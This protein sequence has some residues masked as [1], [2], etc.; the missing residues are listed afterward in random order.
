MLAPLSKL[1]SKFS[2]LRP[3]FL[4]GLVLLLGFLQLS[5]AQNP[6]F[7]IFKNFFVTGDY[8]VSGWV[9][10]APDGS[11]Y[12]PGIISIP[13]TKQPVATSV[14]KGADIVAA[15]L[16]WATVEGNQSA[17]V[18][19]QAFFNGYSLTGTVLGSPN[20]PVSWSSG[21]CSGSAQGSKTMRYY[22]ADV[23]PYLPL[24]T[25]NASPTFG[26][27]VA[28]GN[29]PVRL[30]DSGGNGNSAPFALGASLVVVYRVL[31]P[32]TPLNGIVLYDGIVAPSNTSQPV[33]Q[34]ITGFYGPTTQQQKLTQIV[35]NGQMNKSEFVYLNGQPLPSIYGSAPP[36]P[37]I[38][39][40]WDNPT[41][42]VNGD[43]TTDP[44]TI[45]V[46][47]S[48]SNSGCVSWGAM[49]LST[50]VQ[51]TDHDGLL[52]VWESNQGYTDAVSG[53]FVALPGANP[54]VPDIFVELDYLSN[55]DGQ[56]GSYLHSHLPKQQALDNVGSIYANHGI[57]VHYD[58]GPTV[59]QGD[60]YVIVGGNG[61]N[62]VSEGLVLCT[63]GASLCQFPGQPAIG[64][65]GGFEFF[66]NDATLGNFQSARSQTYHYM[67]FGHSLGGPRSFWSTLGSGVADPTI[68]TVVS[69]VN[70]GPTAT[71]TIRSP[72]GIVKPGD[73]PSPL[74]ACGDANTNRVTISGA[75]AQTALNG[76]FVFKNAVSSAP[77]VNGL[78]T[79]TFKITTANVPN[80]TYSYKSSCA[81]CF[82]EPQLGISYLGPTS[83][84]GHSDFGGGGDSMVTL[85][86]WA[87]DDV[88]GCQADPSQ[89]S[90]VYCNNQVGTTSVQTGT[91]AHELGHDLTWTHGGTYYNDPISNPSLPTYDVNC[92]PNFLSVMNYL[93]QVRGFVDGGFDYS[94]QTL[95]PLSE[96]SNS[97]SEALGIGQ[98]FST[99]PAA[100]LTRWY[101][102]PNALDNQLQNSSGGRFATAHCDGSP[103]TPGEAPAV[104]VDATVA[105]GG[106]F[107]APLD[108]NNDLI[109]P[110]TI[111][112]PGVDLDHNGAIG[113]APF[114]RFN[115]WNVIN[116]QQIGARSSAFGFSQA[117]GL[118]NGGGGLK[119][120]GGGTDNDGG[121]LKNGG[122][123]LKNGGGG[124][125]NGGGGTEQ[126]ET[127]ATST[128]DAPTALRCSVAI[129]SVPACVPSAS[130]FQENGKNVP[131]TWDAPGFGQIRK[132]TIYRAV[133]S[134]TGQ[135]VVLNASKFSPIK[136]LTGAPPS[137]SYVDSSVKNGTT[138]TYLV[139]AANKQGAESGSS[140][141]LV[142]TVK[143]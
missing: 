82:N 96:A 113:G 11:G 95:P 139:T 3:F 127:T 69:V 20:A 79:T 16:Y 7:H 61:G 6:D 15:Y 51:D 91:L 84:S 114:L 107:S 104:R 73:C 125:K 43:V 133:G 112:S 13:D 49:I 2:L 45:S 63:D 42:I 120:G 17:Q 108:F 140:S 5:L 59:Y 98:D 54:T 85:G 44:A 87:F 117:G 90:Q 142:V 111:K 116:M 56:A 131:L 99:G 130:G 124:L 26:A 138:Y 66:Q 25:A 77:D 22:R 37:G 50:T 4:L 34:Q 93:F 31:S 47:P 8:V 121:G 80:G 106:T 64:W 103:Q 71:V 27:L 134:F 24:D 119:N 48:S 14:P 109:T 12:A 137:G 39:G 129:N 143:F 41:W 67:L 123:G 141:P 88:A 74:A 122:G 97:L 70:A 101:S 81:T 30:A 78:I 76:V 18:G 23:R 28:S 32:Q 128:L 132:Y 52:D 33:S 86:L 53:Q 105:P 92:K 65:K 100:H 83:N 40:N 29:I 110:N 89:P 126:D 1:R 60:P 135:Q 57:H 35:S 21:G 58:I 10:G 136:T 36:F 46:V 19:K 75:L 72:Q 118:K 68:P 102:A 38:Y 9:E 62:A 115:E 55:L 94:T